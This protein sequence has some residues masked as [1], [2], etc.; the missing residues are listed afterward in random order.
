MGPLRGNLGLWGP[1]SGH[2]DQFEGYPVAPE[3]PSSW[4]LPG[5]SCGDLGAS[6]VNIFAIPAAFCILGATPVTG[7]AHRWAYSFP[8]FWCLLGA[9]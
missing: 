1:P 6:R 9:R 7:K 2:I 3:R 8:C 5:A 4:G